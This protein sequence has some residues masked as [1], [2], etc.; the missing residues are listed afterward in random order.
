MYIIVVRGGAKSIYRNFPC[1]KCICCTNPYT[2]SKLQSANN[3][4][5]IFSCACFP[6]L[7]TCVLSIISFV[8]HAGVVGTL[9]YVINTYSLRLWCNQWYLKLFNKGS[10]ALIRYSFE[11]PV[12]NI[13]KLCSTNH[14]SVIENDIGYPEFRVQ[15]DTPLMTMHILSS[16]SCTTIYSPNDSC[17]GYCCWHPLQDFMPSQKWYSL[18]S[19]LMMWSR[20]RGVARLSL[21]VL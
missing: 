8:P 2:R 11:L 7:W 6:L 5:H 19:L 20:V 18:W 21:H 4:R 1:N 3:G 9:A 12:M 10:V 13:I 16:L 17:H 14:W 15:T